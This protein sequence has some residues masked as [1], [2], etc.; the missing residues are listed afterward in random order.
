MSLLTIP[1]QALDVT[2]LRTGDDT[3]VIVVS[4]ESGALHLL[5]AVG[6]D[7]LESVNYPG[8]RAIRVDIDQ[9]LPARRTFVT[10]IFNF[11]IT[12]LTHGHPTLGIHMVN[13]VS[14]RLQA[15]WAGQCIIRI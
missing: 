14:K 12:F 15:H 5:L 8:E 13:R 9:R 2:V 4:I 11:F 1:C 7:N 6:T 3:L 10:T